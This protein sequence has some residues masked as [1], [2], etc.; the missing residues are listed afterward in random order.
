[1]V[2]DVFYLYGFD[3]PAGI[4]LENNYGNGGAASDSVNADGQDGSG[5]NNANFSTPADG[6]NPRMQMF[7]WTYPITHEV[8]VNA[9]NYPASPTSGLAGGWGANPPD[10]TGITGALILA[11]DGAGTSPTDACEALIGGPYTDKVVIIDRGNCE[12]GAKAL[13]AQQAGADGVIIANHLGDGL[14]LMGPGAS[15]A[16]VTIAVLFVGQTNGT[17]IKGLVPMPATLRAKDPGTFP[18]NRDSDL[19]AGVIAHEYG[20]GV[21]N[22]LTGG[23]ANVNCLNNQEQMGE[24]WSDWMTLF[25]HAQPSDT[26]T[27]PRPIGTYVGFEDPL[28]GAGI[29]RFPY[30][31][32]NTANPLTYGNIV[33]EAV[34]HG[35]GAVWANTLWEV[36][37]NLVAIYGYDPDIYAGSGG[38]NVAFQLAMDGMKFQPCSPGFVTGR[39]GIL[40]GDQAANDGDN[41]CAIWAGFADRGVGATA[42][43]GSSGVIGDEVENFDLPA[44]CVDLIFANSFGPRWQDLWSATQ[45]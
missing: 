40:A 21:S 34:P 27:T 1:V 44:Q 26:A 22:R 13:R 39:D 30:N 6:A 17:T 11:N 19:D 16:S 20:H 3:E 32:D 43:Q 24:G 5:T 42:S 2:H 37:W 45:P 12:F 14:L 25:L 36:Y 33:G 7:V 23:P 35:V 28:T 29:R 9:T 38:N 15:G 18:P 41:E 10:Q 4:F 8:F 31:T